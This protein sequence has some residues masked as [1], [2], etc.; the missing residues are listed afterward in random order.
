[1]IYFFFKKKLI[2]RSAHHNDIKTLKKI[3]KKKFKF[4]KNM[5]LTIFPNTDLIYA[6]YKKINLN[7]IFS[8]L[9]SSPPGL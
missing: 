8:L 3:S 1:M 9:C 5:V 6:V 7:S 2:L 4:K